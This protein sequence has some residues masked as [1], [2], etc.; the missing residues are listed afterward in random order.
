MIA[1]ALGFA[2]LLLLSRQAHQD[3]VDSAL[4]HVKDDQLFLRRER[5]DFL[6]DA[7]GFPLDLLAIQ[8]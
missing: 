3:A 4:A 7:A 1:I 5:D 8:P 6:K 2:L